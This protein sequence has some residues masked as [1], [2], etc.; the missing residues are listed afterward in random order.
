MKKNKTD[1]PPWSTNHQPDWHIARRF[2]VWL[3]F[4]A[5]GVVVI[6]L[7]IAMCFAYFPGGIPVLLGWLDWAEGVHSWMLGSTSFLGAPLELPAGGTH[8]PV[9][10]VEHG[11][12]SSVCPVCDF[13][14]MT[15]TGTVNQCP[16]CT[17]L[18]DINRV[19]VPTIR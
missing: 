14:C 15:E 8:D 12:R 1:R 2:V 17:H 10:Q 16:N 3:L 13:E 5:S 11:G 4:M 19:A 6:P 7:S 9:E 18:F